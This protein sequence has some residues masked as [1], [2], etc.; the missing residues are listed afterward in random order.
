M[1]EMARRFDTSDYEREAR[2]TQQRDY[3]AQLQ[4]QVRAKQAK[5]ESEKS[6][7]RQEQQ[8]ERELVVRADGK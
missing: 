7:R 3:A 8:R 5:A 4:E 6:Q 2:L 1:V